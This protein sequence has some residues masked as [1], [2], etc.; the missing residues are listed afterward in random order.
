[1][2][3]FTYTAPK[4]PEAAPRPSKDEPLVSLPVTIAASLHQMLNSLDLQPAGQ[5]DQD[6]HGG[7]SVVL[8]V[9][10]VGCDSHFRDIDK[11]EHWYEHRR[12]IR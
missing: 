6:G 2:Q 7:F 9:F 3:E 1:M 10:G 11:G 8:C 12:K 5:S 4:P